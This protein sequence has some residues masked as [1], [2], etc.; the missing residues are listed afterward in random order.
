MNAQVQMASG[1]AVEDAKRE[2][3]ALIEQ[4]KTEG[5]MKEIALEAELKSKQSNQDY[6]Q[7]KDK[8]I[9]EGRLE[10]EKAVEIS[11]DL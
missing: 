5:N 7:D 6:L 3:Q 2:T 8:L 1:K 4:M 11:A 10:K 9:L